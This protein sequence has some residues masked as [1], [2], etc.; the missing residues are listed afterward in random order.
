V[1]IV[2]VE[3]SGLD[4]IPLI[5]NRA[6]RESLL[7]LLHGGQVHR[8]LLGAHA[9]FGRVI[10]PDPVYSLTLETAVNIEARSLQQDVLD[11]FQTVRVQ[12]PHPI[13]PQYFELFYLSAALL[14]QKEKKELAVDID[15]RVLDGWYEG[16]HLHQFVD[17]VDVFQ[18]RALALKVV[19]HLSDQAHHSLLE[20]P[21][22]K[23]QQLLH[24]FP[25][26][27]DLDVAEIVL[28]IVEKFLGVSRTVHQKSNYK[29]THYR[30]LYSLHIQ[31]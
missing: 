17:Y 14:L 26:L 2:V 31:K 12:L 19:N 4:H 20:S 27:K 21:Q 8:H 10:L 24:E 6:R 18:N 7:V 9:Q 25:R 5:I 11:L 29:H 30:S 3:G 28:D 13:L 16:G 22:W 1:G 23:T 15:D